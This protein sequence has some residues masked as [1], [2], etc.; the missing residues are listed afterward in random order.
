MKKYSTIE[1]F[2][3]FIA[4][5]VLIWVLLTTSQMSVRMNKF[6]DNVE[7]PSTQSRMDVDVHFIEQM[8]PHHDS[9]ITMAR[10]ALEK[11]SN[12]DIRALSNN[13]IVSQS[14]ENE[15]M[16]A[17]YKDWTGHDVVQSSMGMMGR[18]GMMSGDTDMQRLENAT[19]FDKEFLIEMIPHHQMAV[20]MANMLE[21][22]T[23]RSEMKKL[24]KD[25]ITAQTSEIELMGKWLSERGQ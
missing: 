24:A 2:G 10:L 9:A 7:V 5:G 20:M 21:V 15:M 1:L 16:K 14:R 8:I 3:A 12:E 25:I 19:D 22:G 6:M 11:S 13:I 18:G 23:Q 4:G 17:W